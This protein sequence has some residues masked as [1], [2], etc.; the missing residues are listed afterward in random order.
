MGKDKILYIRGIFMFGILNWTFEQRLV[1]YKK[2]I[3]SPPT[4][5]KKIDMGIHLEIE[6]IREIRHKIKVWTRINNLREIG[7][8][9]KGIILEIQNIVNKSVFIMSVSSLNNKILVLETKNTK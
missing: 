7:V 9:I 1:V 2:I 4:M 3:I 6:I 5:I 8:E